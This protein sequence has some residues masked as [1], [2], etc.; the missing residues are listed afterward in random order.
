MRLHNKTRKMELKQKEKRSQLN[1]Q[2]FNTNPH[3][4]AK[5]IFNS[6]AA[7]GRPGFSRDVRNEY[8]HTPYEDKK[9]DYQNNSLSNI[10]KPAPLRKQLSENPPSLV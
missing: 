3:Q 6:K 10:S 2:V 9:R 5:K 8:F 1:A 4:Y 7:E